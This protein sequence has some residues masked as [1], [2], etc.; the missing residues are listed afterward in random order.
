M[1][2]SKVSV[3][4]YL[5]FYSIEFLYTENVAAASVDVDD[6][7]CPDEVYY[8]EIDGK[9]A[10]SCFQCN[11]EYFPKN[12]MKGDKVGKQKNVKNMAKTSWG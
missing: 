11:M 7:L 12:Y 3:L 8:P 4:V 2:F 1:I 9:M 6:E 5:L 10:F